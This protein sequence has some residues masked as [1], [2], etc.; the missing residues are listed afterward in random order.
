VANATIRVI[1]DG[2]EYRLF[3]NNVAIGS[4]GT[5]SDSAII[6][7]TLH[8]LFSTYSGNTLDNFVLW[9]RGTGNEYS[10][11]EIIGSEGSE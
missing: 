3:Y 1:K 7:N 9:A 6:N 11:L 10:A 2:T 8:G 5:I 4:A